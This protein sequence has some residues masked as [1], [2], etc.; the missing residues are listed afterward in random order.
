M[1]NDKMILSVV[2]EHEYGE[3]FS[4]DETV[5][6]SVDMKGCKSDMVR[7][8]KAETLTKLWGEPNKYGFVDRPYAL[9][10][11]TEVGIKGTLHAVLVM[12]VSD[13]AK[14]YYGYDSNWLTNTIR[15]KL[16]HI[17]SGW[18]EVD[19]MMIRQIAEMVLYSKCDVV[20]CSHVWEDELISEMCE[21]LKNLRGKISDITKRVI[22]EE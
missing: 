9:S 2:S 20:Y 15:S 14:E 19:Y 1:E 5:I 21:E 17:V 6:L 22:E 7:V 12:K 13:N 3:D 10:K 4:L 11:K 16:N 8:D 18:Y